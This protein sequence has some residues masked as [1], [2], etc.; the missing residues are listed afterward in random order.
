MSI[1]QSVEQF[2]EIVVSTIQREDLTFR[3]LIAGRVG[4]E[5][6]CPGVAGVF[7]TSLMYEVFKALLA[8]PFASGH[9]I[10]WESSWGDAERT[11]ND[12]QFCRL[13]KGNPPVAVEAK[14][15][16]DSPQ[17]VIDDARKLQAQFQGNEK[18]RG[19]VLIL[20]VRAKESRR[21]SLRD[22]C[23]RQ[24][25]EGMELAKLATR[26]EHAQEIPTRLRGNVPGILDILLLRVR[27]SRL[28]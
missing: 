18:G 4:Y 22:L 16:A 11:R 26:I 8:A 10:H 17:G 15:W 1:D 24:L 28:E 7:E 23:E 27:R 2:F 13:G 21:W 12:I 6:Y 9:E 20:H 3:T 25:A 5:D 14:W 19:Y